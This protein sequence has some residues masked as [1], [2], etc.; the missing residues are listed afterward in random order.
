VRRDVRDWVCPE[1][2]EPLDVPDV[3]PLA[4]CEY[5]DLFMRITRGV[6]DFEWAEI[7]TLT[8]ES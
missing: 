4:Y 2:D 3:G 5:C 6:A 1:C 8:A 7:F